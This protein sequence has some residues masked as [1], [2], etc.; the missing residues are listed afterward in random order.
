MIGGK[1]LTWYEKQVYDFQSRKQKVSLRKSR[2]IQS[3]VQQLFHQPN[4]EIC[5]RQFSFKCMLLL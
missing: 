3:K 2:T 5:N 1:T 4:T